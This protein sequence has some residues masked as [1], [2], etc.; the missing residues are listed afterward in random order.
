MKGKF[1]AT[2]EYIEYFELDNRIRCKVRWY[3][4]FTGCH[5]VST[6]TA[7]CKNGDTYNETVGKRIAE[8]RAKADMYFRLGVAINDF[9][10]RNKRKY[11]K[12]FCKEVVHIGEVIENATTS[13]T[14]EVTD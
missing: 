10:N 11:F 2:I 7:S 8:G 5:C 3:N 12:L 6:G 14:G 13:S 1:K 9:Y 4:P